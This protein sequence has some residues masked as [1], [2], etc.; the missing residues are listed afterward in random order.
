MPDAD[1]DT[2]LSVAN[3]LFW[4][5]LSGL[6]LKITLT[7]DDLNWCNTVEN[8]KTWWK[9][10]ASDELSQLPAYKLMQEM[11]EFANVMQGEDWRSQPNFMEYFN[12]SVFPKFVMYSAHAETVYPLLKAFDHILVTEVPPASAIFLEYFERD[13]ED[14]VRALF[15]PDPLQEVELLGGDM[16]LEDFKAF[17]GGKLAKWDEAHSG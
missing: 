8:R 14:R 4:A 12:G 11:N 10:L 15:K 13:N 2:M 17:V 6:D 5:N 16:S 1:T 3:Y 9:Y 7:E